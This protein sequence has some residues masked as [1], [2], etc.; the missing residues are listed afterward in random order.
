MCLRPAA[1]TGQALNPA[2]PGPEKSSRHSLITS[3]VRPAGSNQQQRGRSLKPSPSGSPTARRH[4]GAFEV[5]TIDANACSLPAKVLFYVR[6]H[7]QL[8]GVFCCLA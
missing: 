8:C 6:I 3:P 4:S 1:S 7:V 5:T 2:W